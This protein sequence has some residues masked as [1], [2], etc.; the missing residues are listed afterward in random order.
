MSVVMSS[1]TQ[2][3]IGALIWESSKGDTITRLT[4]NDLREY[5]NSYAKFFTED[6]GLKVLAVYTES[7]HSASLVSAYRPTAS[8]LGMSRNETSLRRMTLMWGVSPVAIDHWI[9]DVKEGLQVV[10]EAVTR[11]G[12]AQPGDDIGVTFGML[13]ISGPGRTNVLTLWRVR[14]PAG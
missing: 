2:S 4:F 9:T 10:E 14:D 1:S 12:F 3:T 5:A 8:I 7:G 6:L 13:D 11:D